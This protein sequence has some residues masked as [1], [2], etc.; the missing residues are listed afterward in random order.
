M[1]SAVRKQTKFKYGDNV[2]IKYGFYRNMAGK[3]TSYVPRVEGKFTKKEYIEYHV[4]ID[5]GNLD[6]LVD[7]NQI[8]IVGAK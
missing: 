5:V 7:E 1:I 6:I 8:E 3:I 2:V 4:K